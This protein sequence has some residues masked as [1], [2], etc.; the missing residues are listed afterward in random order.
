LKD[1]KIAVVVLNYNGKKHLDT[2]FK[3]LRKS[4]YL[5]VNYYLL[6]NASTEDDVAYVKQFYPWVKIIRNPHNNGYCAAY[7]LAFSICEEPYIIC[8]NNDVEVTQNWLEPMIEMA[9]KNPKIAA[10]QPKILSYSKRDYFEYAGASGGEMD[11]F[12]FPF[13]RGRIFDTLEKDEGQY[14]HPKQIFW[15]SGAC[16]FLRASALKESGTLD[17]IIVHHMDEIDLCWRLHLHGYEIW[18][19]PKSVLYHIGGATIK[20]KSFKKTYWNHRNSLYIMFKNYGLGNAVS[21]T[22]V[23]VILDYVALFQAL[24]TRNFGMAKGILWAHGWLLG[25]IPTIIKERRLVQARR[26]LNDKQ[27][28]SKFYQFSIVMDYFM[29]GKKKWSDLN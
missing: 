22:I 1:L 14:N 12:G 10:I 8:L 25:H 16:L 11:C 28:A 7:N 26:K 29:K 18:V 17:E 9:E 6:D 5:N 23:H 21:K 19:E 15:A 27:M 13:M 4:T 20:S 3:S 2:C 24:V